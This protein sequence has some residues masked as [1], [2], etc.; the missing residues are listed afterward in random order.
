MAE[1][2]S[3]E[4]YSRVFEQH[5]EGSLIMADLTRRFYDV[6]VFVPGGIEAQRE[7]ERRAARREVIHFILTQL[8]Q[9]GQVDPNAQEDT[10]P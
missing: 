6:N 1:K 8:S 2:V 9:V 3:P 4:A 7:T 5:H 10:Q